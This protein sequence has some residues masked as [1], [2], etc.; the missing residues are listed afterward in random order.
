MDGI[1]SSIDFSQQLAAALNDLS[2][3]RVY[4]LLVRYIDPLQ[5]RTRSLL[6]TFQNR[7]WFVCSQGDGLKAITTA[8]VNSTAGS[9]ETFGSSGPDVSELL[10]AKN[11]PVNIILR[12]ALTHHGK[13]MMGKKL[14]RAAVSQIAG[15]V[16]GTV[17]FTLDTENEFDNENYTVA[18]SGIQG[19]QWQRT[20]A[21]GTGIYLGM[22]LSASLYGWRFNAGMIEYQDSTALASK[23]SA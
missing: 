14:L 6:L 21:N 13:P 19:V 10:V 18:V 11:M 3:Q 23:V 16:G 8:F 22:T 15:N 1:F 20:K 9:V 5:S 7:Q 12:T 17:T 4:V 2:S